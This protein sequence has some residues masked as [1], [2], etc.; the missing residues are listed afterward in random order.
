MRI[1]K[2][3]FYWTTSRNVVNAGKTVRESKINIQIIYFLYRGY[4]PETSFIFILVGTEIFLVV[5]FY[6][7]PIVPHA[8]AIFT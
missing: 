2:Q 1:A 7:Y 5:L 3:W 4:R 6:I 8:Q